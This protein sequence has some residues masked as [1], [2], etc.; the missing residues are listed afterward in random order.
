MRSGGGAMSLVFNNFFVNSIFP[1]PLPPETSIEEGQLSEKSILYCSLYGYVLL[2]VVLSL[3][4]SLSG[5]LETFS[6]K[7]LYQVCNA[8]LIA[9]LIIYSSLQTNRPVA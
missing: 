5:V 8:I 1:T 3:L 4:H 2:K 6:P 9:T 7:A